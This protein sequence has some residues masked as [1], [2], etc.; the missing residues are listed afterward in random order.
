MNVIGNA[1]RD[2]YRS[3]IE[4]YKQELYRKSKCTNK[5]IILR[6]HFAGLAMQ[7]KLSRTSCEI[8]EL[9]ETAYAVADAM[10]KERN[11]HHKERRE[12]FGEEV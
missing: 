5:E 9:A 12:T 6:D 10:I 1:E 3:I 2:I 4:D 11:S 8:T 7:G